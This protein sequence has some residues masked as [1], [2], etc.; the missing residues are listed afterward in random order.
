M[1]LFHPKLGN[2]GLNL[3]S[4]LK[5]ALRVEP[6]FQE[7]WAGSATSTALAAGKNLNQNPPPPRSLLEKSGLTSDVE[8]RNFCQDFC[9]DPFSF[10]TPFL[11]ILSRFLS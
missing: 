1:K 3:F 9:P 7:R 4:Q 11:E 2:F 5:I 8:S 10:L 6:N